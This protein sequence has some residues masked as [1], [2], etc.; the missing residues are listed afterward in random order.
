MWTFVLLGCLVGLYAFRSIMNIKFLFPPLK[1]LFSLRKFGEI[2][3][4]VFFKAK[5][6]TQPPK[7]KENLGGRERNYIEKNFEKHFP[8]FFYVKGEIWG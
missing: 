1:F 4:D 3:T 7:L 8:K 6:V 5:K 2:F